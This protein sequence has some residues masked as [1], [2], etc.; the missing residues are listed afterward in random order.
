M[1]RILLATRNVHKTQEFAEIL[2]D[3]FEITDLSAEKDLPLIEETGSSF[4]ENAILKAVT[5]SQHRQSL[6]AADDSGLEVDCLGGAPGIFSAR[7][8]GE[9]A[10]DRDNIDKLLGEIARLKNNS[11][12]I[13]ARFRCAIAVARSGKVTEIFRGSV[14]GK[15]VDPPRGSGGFGYDPV[16]VPEGFEE[17]F[18][19]LGA[20][21]KNRIS[22]RACAI[23]Q[24]RERLLA[25]TA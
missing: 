15:I 1:P 12:E 19:E 18:A 25:D 16:F 4:E 22:H 7:Y 9:N 3:E 13:S 8:A 10:S 17:T 5:V 21:V 2:G 11:G 14:D 23:R 6:V 20:D 24:M